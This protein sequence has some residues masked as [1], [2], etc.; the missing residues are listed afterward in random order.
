[1]E[2]NGKIIEARKGK[3]KTI[4]TCRM[5]GK[6]R[7]WKWINLVLEEN[8]KNDLKE[9]RRKIICGREGEEKEKGQELE[10]EEVDNEKGEEAEEE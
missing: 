9:E 1:M 8:Q 5:R 2:E 3:K 4:M 7:R 10:D 6:G